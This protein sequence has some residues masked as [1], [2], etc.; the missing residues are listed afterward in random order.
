M[1]ILIIGGT[2]NIGRNIISNINLKEHEVFSIS[3]KKKIKN[4]KIKILFFKFF[5]NFQKKKN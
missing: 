4:K 2:G 1:K 5:K 3:Q